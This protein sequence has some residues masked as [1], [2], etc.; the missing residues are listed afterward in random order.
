[1][2]VRVS[3]Y[4]RPALRAVAR[5]QIRGDYPGWAFFWD[6]YPATQRKAIREIK[7][8]MLSKKKGASPELTPGQTAFHGGLTNVGNAL[9]LA[10]YKQHA[11][12]NISSD[13][14]DIVERGRRL[15]AQSKKERLE[16][17]VQLYAMRFGPDATGVIVHSYLDG[18]AHEVE[19]LAGDGSTI[20][21]QTV[22]EAELLSIK[23]QK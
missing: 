19:V 15:V 12:E 7:R 4:W 1:M 5:M 8:K 17:A 10:R 23:E 3:K 22:P 14:L 21:V 9:T 20:A 6:S 13:Y 11:R 16:R 18:K 2:P